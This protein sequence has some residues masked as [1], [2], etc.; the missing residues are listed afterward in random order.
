MAEA[1]DNDVINFSIETVDLDTSGI[2]LEEGGCEGGVAHHEEALTILENYDTRGQFIDEIMEVSNLSNL[3]FK[4]ST[5]NW[6]RYD[7]K[8]YFYSWKVF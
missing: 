2:V 5:F 7:V 3:S 4:D 1:S 6:S 8:L